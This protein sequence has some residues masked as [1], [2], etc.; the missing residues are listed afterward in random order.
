MQL[1]LEEMSDLLGHNEVFLI[2]MQIAVFAIL[3]QLDGVPAIGLFEAR[4]A[5]HQECML[6]G[7]EK[8]LSD[9]ESRSASICTVVAGTCSPCPLKAASSSYLLGNVSLVHTVL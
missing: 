7:S 9:L 4:E 8:R 2:L 5:N 1:D 6:F 3:P